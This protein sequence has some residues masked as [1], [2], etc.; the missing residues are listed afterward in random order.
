[1]HILHVY[2]DYEPTHGEDARKVA[3]AKASWAKQPWKELPVRD[4]ELPHL[5]VERSKMLPLVS[6]LIDFAVERA[7]PDDVIAFTN[8]D[9]IVRSDTCAVITQKLS[10]VDAAWCPRRDYYRKLEQLPD[11]AF[12][13]E[14]TPHDGVDMVCF[15]P[16]WWQAYRAEMDGFIVGQPFWDWIFRRLIQDSHTG[17]E[18]KL[19]DLIAHERVEAWHEK[20]V[21]R[22]S[23]GRRRNMSLAWYFYRKRGENPKRYGAQRLRVNPARFLIAQNPL[24]PDFLFV[25]VKKLVLE[26]GIDVRGV[27]HAG[28]H[29]GQEVRFYQKILDAKRVLLFEPNPT[30]FDVLKRWASESVVCEQLALGDTEGT[31]RLNLENANKG[32]SSSILRPKLHLERWPWIPFAGSIDVPQTTLDRYFEEHAGAEQYNLFVIDVQGYELQVLKGAAK[33][34]HCFAALVVEV[35]REELYEGCAMVNEVDAFLADFG[36]ERKETNWVGPGKGS[37]DAFYLRR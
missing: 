5:W 12:T 3:A 1:M 24:H 28:G 8:A 16:R 32:M 7:G 15:R 25:D 13:S 35:N 23:A 37:G 30:A 22:N 10:E 6:D 31:V 9:S 2:T 19:E 14:G 36:F 20:P 27:V 17:K 29:H 21:N 34:L 33:T 26:H 18:T 4:E 11:E